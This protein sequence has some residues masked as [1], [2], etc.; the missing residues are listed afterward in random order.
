MRGADVRSEGGWKAK[1]VEE[2][3]FSGTHPGG[4]GVAL[5]FMPSNPG[6]PCGT[7]QRYYERHF[8]THHDRH[9][10]SDTPE[11]VDFITVTV[12]NL[13]SLNHFIFMCTFV[14]FVF[15]FLNTLTKTGK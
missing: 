15:F 12:L 1:R 4:G 6:G 7:T 8:G 5:T 13:K 14:F 2:R 10:I 9:C 3:Q 11:Y